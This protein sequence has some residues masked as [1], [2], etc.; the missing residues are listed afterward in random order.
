M[1]FMKFVIASLGGLAG[2]QS[3]R[4]TR[5][6]EPG[7]RNLIEHAIGG[8]LLLP[9][10]LLF[11]EKDEVDQREKTALAYVAALFGVGSG[12][13]LGWVLDSLAWRNE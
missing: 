12:V 3:R 9:F 7:W 11:M 8:A 4:F 6:M 5:N 10:V 13:A 2:H 1:M